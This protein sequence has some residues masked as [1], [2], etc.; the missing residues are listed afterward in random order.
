[1]TILFPYF[2]LQMEDLGLSL[3]DI[4]LI[5][6]LLPFV[7]FFALPVSGEQAGILNLCTY[8]HTNNLVNSFRFYW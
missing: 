6:G 7:T 1:M 3:E 4:S 8:L 5:N 2:A